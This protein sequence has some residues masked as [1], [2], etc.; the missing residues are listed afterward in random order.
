MSAFFRYL[1]CATITATAVLFPLYAKESQQKQSSKD[2]NAD[3]FLAS[4]VD[5]RKIETPSAREKQLV[6]ILDH[7]EQKSCSL[8]IE[9]SDLATEIEN[10][11][12]ESGISPA[13]AAA[14]RLKAQQVK[15]LAGQVA[16]ITENSQK[17]SQQV[18]KECRIISINKELGIVAIEAG[19]RHGV[20]K[21]MVFH[22]LPGNPPAELKIT[23]TRPD[24]SGAA[25][26][27]GDINQLGSGM[28]IS[29]VAKKGSVQ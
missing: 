26:T 22:T 28:R 11:I 1:L 16:V 15:R 20:F 21:G 23:I 4:V 7:L 29:A 10:I 27:K 24:I 9:S 2:S 25:V 12:N 14:L 13:R 18:L 8:A 19:A 6:A 17:S 5:C 3:Y